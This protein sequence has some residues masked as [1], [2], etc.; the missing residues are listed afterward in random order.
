MKKILLIF[1]AIAAFASCREK[2]KGAFTVSGTITNAPST[3]VFLQELPF[4]GGQPVILDSGSIDAKGAFSLKGM[5]TEEGLYRLYIENGPDVLIVND[6]DKIRLILDV[7]QYR[8]YKLEGSPASQALHELFEEYRVKDSTLYLTFAQLD[9]LQKQNA[10]DSII[11]IVNQKKEQQIKD[12]NNSVS[13]FISKSQSPA[14]IYYVIGSMASRTMQQDEMKNLINHSADRFKSHSGLARYKSMIAVQSQKAA[15]P[16][17]YPLLGK[18]APEISMPDVS[19]KTVSL[20]SFK[21]KYVLVDF[22]ASWC[23][24]CRKEN[25]NVVAAYNQFK[26]KNFTILGVSLDSKKE[27]WVEA[28]ASDNL[29]WTQISDLKYWD[30]SVVPQ[31]GIDGIPFN[32]LVD[33]E[34]KIVASNLRGEELSKKLA[35]LLK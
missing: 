33:P 5:A 11:S 24:P 6:N 29:T 3:K 21:G 18:Q 2:G 28:I 1:A 26:N 22:W 32:V 7:H 12:L 20:S 14:A 8:S 16:P 15:A 4:T 34:G 13:A 9:S 35:E 30:S 17:A 10:G 23:G 31:Y 27:D 25:P 19:G